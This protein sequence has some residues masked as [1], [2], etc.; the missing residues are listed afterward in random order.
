VSRMLMEGEHFCG[1]E[2][3]EMRGARIVRVKRRRDEGSML[4]V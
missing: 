2:E 4:E 3:A 1:E